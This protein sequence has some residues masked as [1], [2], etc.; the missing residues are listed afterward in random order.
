MSATSHLN[1]YWSDCFEELASV[2]FANTKPRNHPFESECTVVGSPVMAGWLKQFFLYDIPKTEKPQQVLACWDVQML[3]PFVNDWLAKAAT[4]T[5]IGTRVPS[6]HPYAKEVLQ[7]RIWQTIGRQDLPA[8]F[9]TLINYIGNDPKAR[10]RRRWGLAQKLA[11]LFDDYVNYRPEL[12]DDWGK[13][14]NTGFDNQNRWQP[15]LWRLLLE[16]NPDTYLKQ[17]ADMADTLPACGIDA[18]YNR[19]AV[20]HTSAL[21]QAY[22]AFFAELAKVLPVEMYIFNPSQ[23]F[24]IEDGSLKKHIK[25]LIT[26]ETDPHWHDPPHP[27]LSGFGRAT[28][29]LLGTMLDIEARMQARINDNH[30]QWGADQSSTLLQRI[31]QDIRRRFAPDQQKTLFATATRDESLQFHLCHSPLREVEVA[32]DLILRWFDDNAPSQ[33]QPRDVQILVPD[34][35]T[36]APFIESVF[37]VSDFTPEI[38]CSIST[39]PAISAGAIG[40]AFIKLLRLPESRL[41]ASEVVD[42]LEQDPIRQCYNLNAEEISTIRTMLDNANIR[43]GRDANHLATLLGHAPP[44]NEAPQTANRQLPDTV[45]W[46]RGLDRLIAG[47]AIGHGDE[48]DDTISAGELGSLHL[49]NDIEGESAALAGK[50]AQFYED[51]CATADQLA[52]GNQ[53]ASDWIDGFK[54]ILDRF[55]SGTETSFREITEIRK[56]LTVV[57]K[58]SQAAGNPTVDADIVATAVEAQLGDTAPAGQTDTNAVMI[59]PMRTMQV[60]PRKLTL[61]LG[62]NEGVFPRADQRPAFDLLAIKPQYGDRSLRYEDRLAFLE[63]IMST[64]DRLIITYTGRNIS[65]NKQIPPSPAITE[66]LQY[67]ADVAPGQDTKLANPIE[68]KLHGFNPAYYQSSDSD[69]FSYSRD[70]HTAARVLT[71]RIDET[72]SLTWRV[73]PPPTNDQQPVADVAAEVITLEELESFFLNAAKHFYTQVLE[74]RLQDPTRDIVD[75]SEI[76]D[77]DSLDDY[78]LNQNVIAMLLEPPE[79]ADRA[80]LVLDEDLFLRLQE[81]ALIPLGKFGHAK[82]QQQISEIETYLNTRTIDSSPRSLRRHLYSREDAQAQP[83]DVAIDLDHYRITAALPLMPSTTNP[84]VAQQLLHFRYSSIKPKDQLRAWMAHVIGHAAGQRFQ[85]ILVGKDKKLEWLPPL[86]HT[87][88]QTILRELLAHYQNNKHE[89][90][91]FAPATSHAYAAQRNNNK[92]TEAAEDAA[93]QKWN[94]FNFPENS[95]PYLFAAWQDEGP[96]VHDDFTNYATSIWQPFFNHKQ[97]GPIVTSDAPAATG[98]TL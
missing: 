95:D 44:G 32:K 62:L 80:S 69:Y 54:G 46:R 85:S 51:L 42:I 94:G 15:A 78:K 81:R 23:E 49:V 53:K 18:V 2:M 45:T 30:V 87:V 52:A 68:H 16:E 89:I 77:T 67:L 71:N 28:Q 55:F 59:S 21:P 56:G 72:D 34:M 7:W 79:T 4:G 17:F 61:L 38:P 35:D 75:D 83:V 66:F 91:P 65:N 37:C 92:P 29:A 97:E 25:T 88:A 24:W 14:L 74:I 47:F 70:N 41:A 93:K 50:L 36:Y 26:S 40:S 43:W 5:A 6:E 8:D 64:R 90:M 19:I 73:P 13:G 9:Q 86:E 98:D 3:H 48:G 39:R 96:I 12:L 76:F 11:Q 22:M 57:A 20:F 58:A 63:A 10:D 27:L 31:Q 1:I 84:N 82:T 60:T 33:P